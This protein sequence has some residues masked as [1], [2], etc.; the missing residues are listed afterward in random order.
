[1]RYPVAMTQHMAERRIEAEM[2]LAMWADMDE[3][4][5]GELVDGHLVD[6]GTAIP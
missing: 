2:T 1:M 5:P 3:D 6:P 4:E